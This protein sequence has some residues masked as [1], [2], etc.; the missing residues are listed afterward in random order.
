MIT[1]MYE[2][3]WTDGLGKQISQQ[4]HE[5]TATAIIMPRDREG[6]R[7][8]R[9][10]RVGSRNPEDSKQSRV[11]FVSAAFGWQ[12]DLTLGPASRLLL[13][14]H[15]YST[16]SKGKKGPR[17]PLS[18]RPQRVTVPRAP[19]GQ[20]CRHSLSYIRQKA[21]QARHAG[22]WGRSQVSQCKFPATPDPAGERTHPAGL[23]PKAKT[24]NRQH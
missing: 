1:R 11:M 8:E 3:L 7:E 22:Q 23:S 15:R 5:T 16:K 2:K 12:F 17:G 9:E 6:E 20:D 19:Q 18:L 14:G 10:E 21:R 4:Y 24:E 13:L